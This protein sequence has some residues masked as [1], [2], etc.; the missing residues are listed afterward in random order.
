MMVNTVDSLLNGKRSN[1]MHNLKARSQQMKSANDFDRIWQGQ[2][3]KQ[4]G[5]HLMSKTD[6]RSV[7][8]QKNASAKADAGGAWTDQTKRK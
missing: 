5:K 7:S 3:G 8:A 1:Q 2:T 4:M 6:Q